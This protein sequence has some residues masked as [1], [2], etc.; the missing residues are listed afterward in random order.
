MSGGNFWLANAGY[1]ASL[2]E[3]PVLTTETRYDAEAWVGQNK[4]KAMAR[5]TEWPKVRVGDWPPADVS[6]EQMERELGLR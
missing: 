2:P 5:T 1:V 4:P 6:L 3:L